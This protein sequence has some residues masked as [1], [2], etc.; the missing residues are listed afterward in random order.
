MISLCGI[1]AKAFLVPGEGLPTRIQSQY[2]LQR[3]L[4]THKPHGVHRIIPVGLKAY[5]GY[6]QYRLPRPGRA[7]LQSVCPGVNCPIIGDLLVTDILEESRTTLDRHIYRGSVGRKVDEADKG[8]PVNPRRRGRPDGQEADI[9]QSPHDGQGDKI[10]RRVLRLRQ[11]PLTPKPQP[12]A[13]A[14]PSA[15]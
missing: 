11:R 8:F 4:L 6:Q 10:L 3:G 5:A 7:D 2:R 15:T 14:P 9:R 12:R 1:A 13:R